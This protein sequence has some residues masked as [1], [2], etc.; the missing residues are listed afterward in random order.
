ML[1]CISWYL[2][3]KSSLS[4]QIPKPIFEV[5]DMDTK[6]TR[7]ERDRDNT[8]HTKELGRGIA[9]PKKMPKSR[10]PENTRWL[11]IITMYPVLQTVSQ[12]LYL[13]GDYQK[14]QMLMVYCGLS[15]WIRWFSLWR[16]PFWSILGTTRALWLSSFM[17]YHAD[18]LW[19][20]GMWKALCWSKKSSAHGT[21]SFG[22][23]VCVWMMTFE[24]FM[25]HRSKPWSNS[26]LRNYGREKDL[27]HVHRLIRSASCWLGDLMVILVH[28]NY[29]P[30]SKSVGLCLI[31]GMGPL[32]VWVG[33]F[34]FS[35]C[36]CLTDNLNKQSI[37]WLT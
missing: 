22:V 19:S 20:C 11:H 18:A 14:P 25:G 21:F 15:W 6:D 27:C 24:D 13:F 8:C 9:T 35:R 30:V 17:P 5:V 34:C 36:C 7:L 32:G 33:R 1:V 2:I 23:C 28:L 12:S 26:R 10:A 16:L 31:L 37:S 29:K 3:C 4:F